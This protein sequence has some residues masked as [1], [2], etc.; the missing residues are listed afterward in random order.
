MKQTAS[1][2]GNLLARASRLWNRYLTE[3]L[4]ARGYRNLK[5]SLFAVLVPLFQEDGQ[6]TVDL[7]EF[8]G[9]TKQTM[10]IYVEELRKRGYVSVKRNAED[11]RCLCLTLT[12]KG[13]A[14]RP[15]FEEAERLADQKLRNRLGRVGFPQLVGMLKKCI[16]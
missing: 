16:E 12:V 3:A 1:N 13:K 6:K 9:L 11:K 8:S 4:Q 15:V 5:P 7:M 10:S 2:T 14:L